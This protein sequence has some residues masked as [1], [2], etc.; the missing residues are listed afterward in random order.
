MDHVRPSIDETHS[1]AFPGGRPR[2]ARPVRAQQALAHLRRKRAAVARRTVQ[3]PADGSALPGAG[4]CACAG[5]LSRAGHPAA[6]ADGEPDAAGP[7]LCAADRIH[8]AKSPDHAGGRMAAGQLLPDRG[9]DPAGQATFAQG[10]QPQPAQT[11][12]GS[13][14][15]PS[16]GVRHRAGDDFAQRCAD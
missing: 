5:R 16:P 12:R 2:M 11:G 13:L 1:L 14:A 9:A 7:G 15:G 8:A 10:V 6:P 3:F 4:A